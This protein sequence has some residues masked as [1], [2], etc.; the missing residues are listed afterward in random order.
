MDVAQVTEWLDQTIDS[1]VERMQHASADPSGTYRLQFHAGFT[2]RDATAI[3]PYLRDLGISH[4]Y[5]S[6]YLRARAGSMHGYDV[7]D[8]NQ[9]NPA[10][11]DE[12]DYAEFVAS[13]RSHGLGH[14]LDVVP[15][16]MAAGTENPWWRDVLENGPNSPYSNFFDIEWHPIKGELESR[17]LMPIL[18]AQYG[19]V[20]ENGQLQ[21]EHLDGGFQIRYFDRA[22]PLGPKTTAPLLAHG[23]D[24]LQTQLR[25]ESDDFNEYQS[26][27]TALEHLPPP[28]ATSTK[29]VNERQREKEIIKRRLRELEARQ[30][31]VADFVATNIERFNGRAGEPDSFDWLDKLLQQQSYRLCHWRAAADEI[32]YRRFFDVND[33]AAICTE[34]PEVFHAVHSFVG[35]Q[36]G[37]GAVD[38]LRVDH[39]DGLFDPEN[40]LWRL[41]WDYLAQSAQ[42]EFDRLSNHAAES[43]AITLTHSLDSSAPIDGASESDASSAVATALVAEATQTV[44]FGP[45]VMRRLCR[46]LNLRQ[47]EDADLVAVF[48]P[49]SPSAVP[50][51]IWPEV[52]ATN[53]KDEERPINGKAISRAPLYVVVEK[54][55]G[56][57]EPLPE[58]WPVAGTTGYDYTH[59][60]NGLFIYPEGL[61][62]VEKNYRRFTDATRTFTD[63]VHDCKRLI[64][65]FS[66]SSELQM[67]AHYLNR[68]SEQHRK[69]R[70]FTLNALRYALREVL[71]CFP[72]YRTYTSPAG[73]SDRDQRFV[74]RAVAVAKRRNPAMDPTT[75]DF[76]RDVL[77]LR[78]PAGLSAESIRLREEFAG[79]F[80]Q[81]TS[82]VMAKGVE[83]TAFYVYSPLLSANEVGGDPRSAAVSLA[84][85]HLQNKQR[86]DRQRRGLL[87]TTTHDTKRSEDVRA[88]IDVLTEVPQAW[89]MA[90]AQWSKST[91]RWRHEVD[92]AVAPSPEDEH[93]FYQSLI[94]IW[95]LGEIDDAQRLSIT[96]RLQAYM[97]KA[98]H[99][100]KQR[101]SWINPHAEYDQTV[102]Q[103]VAQCLTPGKEN[104]FLP[105]FETFQK[106]TLEAGLYT[107]LSQTV[108]KLMS[109]GVPDV[110]QG[111]E[112]WDFSLVDP[113]NRRPVDYARRA[114]LLTEISRDWN[115]HPQMRT[116]YAE[117]LSGSPTDERL[118]L[119]VTWR[120]LAI[121]RDLRELFGTGTYVPLESRGPAAEHIATFA[122]CDEATGR[123]RIIVVA[124]RWWARLSESAGLEG[125]TQAM[126]QAEHV[127]CDTEIVL[128]ET[129]VGR[130][131][132][133][134]TGE[135][136]TVDSSSLRLSRLLRHFPVAVLLHES[137]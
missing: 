2:F 120:L 124:P 14:I 18:G 132:N 131:T 110:Y 48:G 55:L 25:P 43:V 30:P 20:L 86:S 134:F 28:T 112:L 51:E 78:H 93:L 54:I 40:F 70:D 79:R 125:V 87:A 69:S 66:M 109:P 38:G 1:V 77:L 94:G 127:W 96:E 34:K 104:T 50:V 56:P 114:K 123:A 41:Q 60:L 58:S 101:T 113:D 53:A 84:A 126:P 122:W 59:W 5:A 72:V 68:I 73:V 75:F 117:S 47:P 99:E 3:V 88:R 98:T 45:E 130:F 44:S 57:D 106:Q 16:H 12:H 65:R 42:R 49:Y 105:A 128:P 129:A 91:Q 67:L 95:P 81:V 136:E 26:I 100:A 90:V 61:V 13:L 83:D 76:L 22:L 103:L 108:L 89:R 133:A 11:G 19:E 32:N 97:E 27:I 33:L 36:L 4:V 116:D 35:R 31:V 6:P 39:V 46:R 82:P 137:E 92:G 24:Q 102:R 7:C 15:N 64:L 52:D 121:R 80:Q 111:Q 37:D 71:A 63:V 119:F 29:A 85:F 118:K 74:N 23:I 62:E 135:T 8:Y 10:I 115:E 21:I 9:L 17:V 107:A